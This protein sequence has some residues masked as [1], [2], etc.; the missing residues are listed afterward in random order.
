MDIKTQKMQIQR[1]KKRKMCIS[2][3]FTNKK[4]KISEKDAYS[5]QMIQMLLCLLF[6]L[7]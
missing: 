3:V 6:I 4:T 7:W 1:Q 2:V 5:I